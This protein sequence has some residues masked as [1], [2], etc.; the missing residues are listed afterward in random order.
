MKNLDKVFFIGV[1]GVGMGA[2]AQYL[3]MQNRTVCGSDRRFSVEK[4]C[5]EKEQLEAENVKCFPQDGSGITSD[6]EY[7]V[8]ST[9]IEEDNP[10]LLKAKEL[11]LKVIHRSDALKMLSDE[12]KTIAISGTSGKSTTVGMLFHI[13]SKNNQKPSLISGAGLCE[14]QKTG[15]IG[16]AIA[17][18]G[19]WLI[20]EADESDGSL[21]KYHPE[22]G[23][24]L[25]IDKDHKELSELEELFEIFK[26]NS[27]K[28]IVNQG[29]PLSKNLSHYMAW[30]FIATDTKSDLSVGVNG[31]GFKQ[32]GHKVYFKVEDVDFELPVPGAHNMENALAAIAVATSRKIALS[33]EECAEA[34]K[35]YAGIF[36]RHQIVCEH[37]D[38]VL[39]DDFAHNPAKISASIKSCYAMGNR[40]LAWFQPHGYGPTRFLRKELVEEIAK[41][42]RQQ[43]KFWM[44]E[45]YY[46]GG[47][48]V[49]DI[50]ANDIVEDLKKVGVSASFKVKRD[51]VIDEI[52]NDS[53]PGDVILLMGARDPSLDT[54]AESVKEKLLRV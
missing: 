42:L 23:V 47:T 36:R 2:L 12:K 1:A 44:S 17:D 11:G 22:I 13:L 40:I 3:G 41:V 31:Y 34:L 19:K 46:A 35:S 28:L 18:D 30:D 27:E 29:H 45:I 15:R 52:I 9:A 8:I 33:L 48:A 54:F 49:K 26:N 14:I 24:I 51:D 53:K 39:V 20:I 21:I 38:I 6:L 37:N 43:D 7:I 50:S 4:N 5:H 25:N 10:E 16:N 32:K